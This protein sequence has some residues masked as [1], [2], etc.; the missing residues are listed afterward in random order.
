MTT[1]ITPQRRAWI[2]QIMG[3]PISVHLHGPAVDDAEAE[4]RVGAFFADL[5]RIDASMAVDSTMSADAITSEVLALCEDAHWRTGGWFDARRVPDL[6]TGPRVNPSGLVKGWA[7]EQA[8]RRL[9]TFAGHG[10]CVTAGRDVLVAGPDGQI[11]SERI[12][13]WQIGVEDPCDATR[14]L[15]TVSVTDG[16]V[17]TSGG[18]RVIDPFTGHPAGR[19][20]AVTVIGPSL[21]WAD[22]YATAAA[23]RGRS[24]VGWIDTIDGYEAL[25]VDCHG[26][27]LTTQGWPAP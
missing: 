19:V 12:R 25:I 2:D 9:R 6:A 13:P 27:I 1:T 15:Q 24:A 5:Q 8:A 7:V 26:S 10:W 22:V 14:V 16:A 17:A 20:A 4:L 21:M 3:V 18:I 23:A 11:G